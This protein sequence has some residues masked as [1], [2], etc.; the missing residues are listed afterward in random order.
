MRRAGIITGEVLTGLLVVVLLLPWWLPAALRAL[1]GRHGVT[2]QDYERIGYA[3]FALSGVEVDQPAVR[4]RIS[5]VEM[6]TPLVWAWRHWRASATGVKAGEWMVDVPAHTG[7]PPPVEPDAGWMKLR[8]QLQRIA[9]QLDRWLPRAE[10]GAGRVTWPGGTIAVARAEWAERTLRV[11]DLAWKKINADGTLIFG[12]GED[13]PLR[14]DLAT[15]DG[16]GRVMLR[17]TGALV[18]GSVHWWKQPATLQA[19]FGAAGWRPRTAELTA[20]NWRVAGERVR[21]GELFTSVTGDARI[22]WAEEGFEAT[23]R[24]HGEP[25]AERTASSLDVDLHARG[26]GNGIVVDRLRANLP[27]AVAQLDQPVAVSRRG[28]LRSGRAHFSWNVDLAALPWTGAKGT[29]AGEAT[30]TRGAGELP[31]VKFS[32]EASDVAVRNYVIAQAGFAGELAWP[33]LR[34]DRARIAL[35]DGSVAEASGAWDFHKQALQR[36]EVKASVGSAAL[37]AWLPAGVSFRQ[38]E[39]KAH[40]HGAWP[41]LE[42]EGTLTMTGV[43]WPRVRATEAAVEWHGKGATIDVSQAKVAAPDASLVA[44]GSV[45]PTEARVDAWE[46]ASGEAPPLRLRA[47][48]VVR[49]KPRWQATEIGLASETTEIGFEG[50]VGP[51]GDARLRVRGL[52][53]AQVGAWMELPAFAWTLRELEVDG[54]WDH[55]PATFTARADATAELREHGAVSLALAVR[56]EEGGILLESLNVNQGGRV[57]A[58]ANGRVPLEIRPAGGAEWLTAKRDGELRF[59]ATTEPDAAFWADLR[60]ATGVE[61]AAPRLAVH[62][63]GTWRAPKGEATLDTTRVALDPARFPQQWPAIGPVHVRVTG[64]QNEVRLERFAVAVEGQRVQAEG[65][66]PLAGNWDALREDPLAFL[67]EKAEL[68]LQIPDAEVAPFVRFAPALL[69]PKGRV[70]ADLRLTP[71]GDM[72]GTL[73]LAGLVTKP[74]GGVGVLQDVSAKLRLTGRSVE[75]DSVKG[76]AGGQTVTISGRVDLPMHEEPRYD[77][78]MKGENLPFVRSMGLLVRGNLDLTL[79]TPERKPPVIGGK[80]TLRDSLFLSDVRAMIPGGPRG[81]T[82]RPPYFAVETEPFRA[83]GLAVDVRGDKFLRLRTPVFNGTAST[84]LQLKGTLGSPR[85]SGEATIDEGAVRLPFAMFSVEQGR[86]LLED[87]PPFEPRLQITATSRRYDYDLRMEVTGT[88]SAP[89]L[90]FSSSPPLDSEQIL[91]MVMAGEVPNQAITY[92]QRQRATRLGAFVGQSLFSTLGGDGGMSDRLTF[93]SGEHVSRQGRETYSME[94]RLNDRWS[95][96]GEYDEFDD[97]NAGVKWR[98]LR[99]KKPA[100]K[101]ESEGERDER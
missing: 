18:E 5:R 16:D 68:R 83:W 91:L 95:L 23:V 62:A 79:T 59:D 93:S 64:D 8:G 24:A 48:A 51:R 6:D 81:P 70:Q 61:L 47:P 4:V 97:Y 45:T 84:R 1:G 100:E 76:T 73:Q 39:F 17:S 33:R 42:H 21:V 63:S 44:R 19:R 12:A 82:Q 30:I 20:R 57:V 28:E 99:E 94:Y 15:T 52:T 53:S 10:T 75:I 49:W 88:A 38:A 13:S 22:A 89:N 71:G 101:K 41:E 27:G 9:V 65:S 3:R 85:L 55:G 96:T 14:L 92:S 90:T 43:H 74:I 54:R 72:R 32:A 80:I 26:D 36:G 69:A 86:V 78:K 7:S 35:A 87:Q 56:S 2:F 37:A 11:T 60:A 40:G 25:R 66:V 46:I 29:A 98:A 31:R 50:A 58:Q 67:Q 77:L 34:L